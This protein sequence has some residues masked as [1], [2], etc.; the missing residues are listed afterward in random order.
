M[1]SFIRTLELAPGDSFT[2]KLFDREAIF[3]DI[4]TTGFSPISNYI[5]L[6][7]CAFRENDQVQIHQYFAENP[8]QEPEILTS[9]LDLCQSHRKLF[10]YNG[11][12]FDLPFIMAKCKTYNLEDS[13]SLS[14]VTDLFKA[15]SGLRFLLRTENYKQVTLEKF[16]GYDRRDSHSGGELIPVY[17]EYVKS[18]DQEALN[19]ML[20]HNYED[21]CG[22][23][24]LLDLLKYNAILKG[25]FTAVGA[26]VKRFSEINGE[27]GFDLYINLS[28]DFCLPV[29]VSLNTDGVFLSFSGSGGCIRV[30][31]YK[32]QLKYYFSDY[33]NYY[34]LPE[35]DRAVHKSVAAFVD[36]D[37][38]EKCHAYNC[39]E[40]RTGVFLPQWSAYRTPVFQQDIKDKKTYFE[41]DKALLTDMDFMKE[42]ACQLLHWIADK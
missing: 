19:F 36:H 32:G 18:P 12:G 16:F 42:Y 34:Y 22:M 31:L 25:D 20:L 35:E 4:E 27:A 9:F 40:P 26:Q 14:M 38:R 3:F 21:I 30:A 5:Y 15:A 6:I 1:L 29:P 23:I 28:F 39:Y 8:S 24:R 7:G 2:E 13:L 33:K 10:S 37:H 11:S 41:V 17:K